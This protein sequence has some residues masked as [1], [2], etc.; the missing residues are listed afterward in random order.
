MSL[1][2]FVSRKQTS[3][4][5][6]PTRFC[7]TWQATR[8]PATSKRSLAFNKNRPGELSMR[9]DPVETNAPAAT[10][11]AA[12]T[13]MKR[14]IR[15]ISADPS[16]RATVRLD[17]GYRLKV[18]LAETPP[19]PNVQQDRECSRT[20]SHRS[21]SSSQTPPAGSST[22]T[23]AVCTTSEAAF[24]GVSTASAGSPAGSSSV[25]GNA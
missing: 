19:E 22:A 20:A 4:F 8:D 17:Q 1:P 18:Q 10:A 7:T 6:N 25:A 12:R 2:G 16:P 3:R 15:G 23:A 5:V 11:I 14:T 13:L 24:G 9:A 21:V